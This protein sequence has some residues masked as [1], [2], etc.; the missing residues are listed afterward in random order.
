MRIT[1]IQC[2]KTK[3]RF[4]TEGVEA[5]RKRVAHYFPFNIETAPDL[6]NSR[7]L[8]MK[9]V[10]AGEGDRLLKRIGQADSE[11]AGGQGESPDVRDW[12]ALWIFGSSL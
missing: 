1:L 6:K 5:F 9:E 12:G 3:D 11:F 8:T 7:N 4:I 2:G 10:Q